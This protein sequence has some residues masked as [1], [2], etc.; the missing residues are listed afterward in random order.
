[1]HPDLAPDLIGKK[2]GLT[3]EYDQQLAENTSRLSELLASSGSD[4][5]YV[6]SEED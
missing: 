4:K 5:F 6:C 3:T 2:W 1:M